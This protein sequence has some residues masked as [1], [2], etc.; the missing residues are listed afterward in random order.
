MFNKI[1]ACVFDTLKKKKIQ[2]TYM[3]FRSILF[4]HAMLCF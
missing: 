1:F 3:I 4:Q 2:F